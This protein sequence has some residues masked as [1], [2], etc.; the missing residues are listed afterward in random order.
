MALGFIAGAAAASVAAVLVTGHR[1]IG[2]KRIIKH[3]TLVDVTFTVG[4]AIA[5]AGTLTGFM[6]AIVA[7]LFMAILLTGLQK[8]SAL[9]DRMKTPSAEQDDEHNENGWIYNQAPYV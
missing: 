9:M 7:G 2:I 6:V 8:L 4:M 1:T 5:F 3:A